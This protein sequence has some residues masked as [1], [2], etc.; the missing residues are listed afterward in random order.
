VLTIRPALPTDASDLA[1]L[2]EAFMQD[3]FQRPWHGTVDALGRDGCG[4]RF[5]MSVAVASNGAM[6][7]FV[8]WEGSYDLHHC[9]SGGHVID[10]Y[11]RPSHRGRGVALALVADVAERVRQRGGH[12]VR[13]QAV[14]TPAVQ[15][16]YDRIAVL[17]PGAECNV[18]G[19]A[20]RA[21]ADL[22]GLPARE[23]ARRLP[24]RAWNYEA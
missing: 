13:G 6:V 3:A 16:M 8:A 18:G 14:P 9:V 24:P 21:L 19:R 11:V 20:F 10:M 2:L 15:R 1:D 5:E 22:A 12:Y 7:G 4:A 17:F 23:A